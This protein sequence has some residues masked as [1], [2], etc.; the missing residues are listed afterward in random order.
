ME[1][2]RTAF[3]RGTQFTAQC[4][5]MQGQVNSCR[6]RYQQHLDP[7]MVSEWTQE[8]EVK[9]YKLHDEIGNKWAVI[10]QKFPGRYFIFDAEP[11]IVSRIIFTR[12]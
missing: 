6:F 12:S 3:D 10:A 5:A 7:M 1:Y 2:D 9:L 4:Q 11:I 8:E